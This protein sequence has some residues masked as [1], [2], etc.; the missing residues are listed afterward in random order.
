MLGREPVMIMG[1]CQAA[2]HLAVE[3]GLKLQPAQEMAIVL[4]IAALLSFIA[5]Q[6]VTPASSLAVGG[7]T[8]PTAR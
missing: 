4:F 2:I 5:R 1:L 8:S 6:Q 3:F 7:V